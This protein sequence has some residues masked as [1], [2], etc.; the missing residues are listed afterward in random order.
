MFTMMPVANM[1]PTL[2]RALALN[3]IGT[4]ISSVVKI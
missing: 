3:Q 2:R 1:M 4:G